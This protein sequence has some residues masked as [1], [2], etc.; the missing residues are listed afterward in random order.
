MGEER[1][2]M[3][4]NEKLCRE[5]PPFFT[6]PLFLMLKETRRL[7]CLKWNSLHGMFQVYW[8]SQTPSLCFLQASTSF[9][10][11][12]TSSS[13]WELWSLLVCIPHQ[14]WSA[15]LVGKDSAMRTASWT[16]LSGFMLCIQKKSSP[17]PHC[18][19]RMR[20]NTCSSPHSSH[21]HYHF[22]CCCSWGAPPRSCV[23]PAGD[24]ELLALLT[25]IVLLCGGGGC[26]MKW[27]DI[28]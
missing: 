5:D 6:A 22:Q 23:R 12:A 27:D 3:S 26:S 1:D 20:R 11:S 10:L 21:F 28:V 4:Y 13:D 9:S 8:T 14:T 16:A 15:H 25:V 17:C 7:G 2:G 24:G 18:E 19:W